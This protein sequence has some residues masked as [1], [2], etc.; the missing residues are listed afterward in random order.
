MARIDTAGW[1]YVTEGMEGKWERGS[2][3]RLGGKSGVIF[4]LPGRDRSPLAMV[5]SL[6]AVAAK[7]F[8]EGTTPEDWLHDADAHDLL[9]AQDIYAVPITPVADGTFFAST[10][11]LDD[12]AA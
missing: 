3:S 9:D 6:L 4:N 7:A 2:L 5:S 12:P 1:E 10:V 11:L 8:I